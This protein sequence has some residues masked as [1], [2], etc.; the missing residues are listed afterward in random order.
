VILSQT[1]VYA[2]RA[3]LCLA[4]HGPSARVR[5][6]DIAA[7]LA[8]PRNY[9]SKILH[10]LARAGVLVSSRGPGGGFELARPARELTLADVVEPFDE[11]PEETGCLLGRTACSDRDPCAA[12]ERW[13]GVSLSVK[14]FFR[15]TSIAD[16]SRDGARIFT[17][18]PGHTGGVHG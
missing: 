7:E 6:D 10:G 4:G 8:V 9:L 3:T 17:P 11:L 5:V 15:D 1:A 2:L 14:K 12:H 16:L 13:K 18:D